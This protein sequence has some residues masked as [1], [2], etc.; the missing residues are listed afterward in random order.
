MF[1]GR[2][3]LEGASDPVRK[4]KRLR[5]FKKAR[6]WWHGLTTRQPGMFAHWAWMNEF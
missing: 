2:R 6:R 5:S 3:K 1:A 4:Y